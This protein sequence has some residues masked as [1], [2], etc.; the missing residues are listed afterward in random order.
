MSYILLRYTLFSSSRVFIDWVVLP[1]L[2]FLW[3]YYTQPAPNTA[4]SPSETP[5]K[6]R[7][8]SA[9][10]FMVMD[11]DDEGEMITI[12]RNNFMNVYKKTSEKRVI[13]YL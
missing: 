4:P 8:H 1:S 11:D 7:R 3:G 10:T 12:D 2:R 13:T 6:P 5:P 9:V